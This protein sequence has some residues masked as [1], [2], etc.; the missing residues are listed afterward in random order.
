[1][2][3]HEPLTLTRQCALTGVTRSTRYAPQIAAKPDEQEWALL[4]LIDAEYTR[5]PFFGSRKMMAYLHGME[6]R[7]G[8]CQQL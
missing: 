2:S 4:A 5:Q 1:V 8:T 3:P 7:I 6:Y